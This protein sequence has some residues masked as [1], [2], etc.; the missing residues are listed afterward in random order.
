MPAPVRVTYDDGRTV[1]QIVPVDHWLDNNRVARM[2]FPAGTV[3]RVEIDADGYY[4]DANR[5][6]GIWTASGDS[7]E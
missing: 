7:T 1:D 3:S 6:N 2:S 5:T 4:P